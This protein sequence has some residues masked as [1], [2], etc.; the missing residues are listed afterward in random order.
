MDDTDAPAPAR[1]QWDSGYDLLEQ[2]HIAFRFVMP[3]PSRNNPDVTYDALEVV[4][5]KPDG[6]LVIRA[7]DPA[8]GGMFISK[9]PGGNFESRIRCHGPLSEQCARVVFNQILE[10]LIC[11]H[12]NGQVHGNLFARHLLFPSHNTLTGVNELW[13]CTP[14]E[15]KFYLAYQQQRLDELDDRTFWREDRCEGD[16]FACGGLLHFALTVRF[17]E[18]TIRADRIHKATK[19]Q[20]ARA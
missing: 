14:P 16:V 12:H 18:S 3:A 19:T 13:E 15:R 17:P 4:R 5:I 2:Q 11:M 6:S 8:T 20:I 9:L 1:A 7:R 10:A